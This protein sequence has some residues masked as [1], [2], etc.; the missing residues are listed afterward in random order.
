MQAAVP[1]NLSIYIHTHTLSGHS[2]FDPKR[3][4]QLLKLRNDICAQK[5]LPRLLSFTPALTGFFLFIKQEN[6]ITI[7]YSH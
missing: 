6:F 1:N 2:Y 4:Q 3:D 7:C 5:Y